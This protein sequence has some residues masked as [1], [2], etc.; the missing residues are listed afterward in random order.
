MGLVGA[1][2][3]LEHALAVG[4]RDARPSVGN[5]D[6]DTISVSC[7]PEADP[8]V[9]LVVFHGIA[10]QVLHGLFQKVCVG[11]DLHL[12]CQIVLHTQGRRLCLAVFD[13]VLDHAGQV[14]RS[15][16]ELEPAG[17]SEREEQELL[18]NRFEVAD[19]LKQTAVKLL[20]GRPGGSAFQGLL[21]FDLET[22]QRGLEFVRGISA[23]TRGLLEAFLQPVHHLVEHGDEAI[24]L[25]V[26]GHRRNA[27]VEPAGGD[28]LGGAGEH[29][30]RAQSAMS[31]KPRAQPGQQQ[32]RRK[33][34]QA[35]SAEASH[36]RVELLDVHTEDQGVVG[37]A[38]DAEAPGLP[39]HHARFKTRHSSR[40]R[41]P[42]PPG[43]LLS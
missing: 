28:A 30:D 32:H 18:D 3:P 13:D 24:E 40:Q 5:A 21:Q 6:A 2:E 31:Q 8:P 12:C 41:R 27:L 39:V 17:I 42:L 26:A 11:G 19:F 35:G 29:G 15:A 9:R 38:H 33:P 7:Q 25:L 16:V 10:G 36:V 23:K 1:V 34:Q 43:K 14:D 37:I 22:S 20:L 4:G